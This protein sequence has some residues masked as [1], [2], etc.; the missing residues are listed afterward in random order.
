MRQF[1]GDVGSASN[2]CPKGASLLV[3]VHLIRYAGGV[4]WGIFQLNL[5]GARAVPAHVDAFMPG[6]DT[7]G[8]ALAGVLV[9]FSRDH[10]ID[11]QLGL[12]GIKLDNKALEFLVAVGKGNGQRVATLH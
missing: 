4:G 2:T 11:P 5:G 3:V 10:F 12:I 6:V 9:A 1:D 7:E 8:L